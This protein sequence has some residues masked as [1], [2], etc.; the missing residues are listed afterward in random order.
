MTIGNK[1]FQGI[2]T[3]LKEWIQLNYFD[4]IYN[5]EIEELSSR[6]INSKIIGR[7]NITVIVKT[8]EGFI[9]G[10]YHQNTLKIT[11]NLLPIRYK[12]NGGY[13][14][15]T[16]INFY[17]IEPQIFYTSKYQDYMVLYAD[18]SENGLIGMC[19]AYD[20][21]VSKSTFSSEFSFIYD[22][23]YTSD[24]FVGK[25]KPNTFEISNIIILQW[26]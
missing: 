14:L 19:S 8:T 9:F 1:E 20:L 15:F 11:K 3:K 5:S 24:L 2:V 16:F 4:I 12:Q 22:T 17:G 21:R 23:K 6:Q 26:Y 13:F 18:D 7:K 10:S 25:T